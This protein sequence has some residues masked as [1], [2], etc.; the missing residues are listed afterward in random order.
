[1]HLFNPVPKGGY[2]ALN[3]DEL[4][5]MKSIRSRKICNFKIII[6]LKYA[7]LKK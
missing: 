2:V 6:Y 1:M 7:K 5:E 3:Q 4:E